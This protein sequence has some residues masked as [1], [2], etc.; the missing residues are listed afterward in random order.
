MAQDTTWAGAV[1]SEAD[2]NAFLMGEGGA[3]TTFT[4]TLV[5]SGAVTKT[6]TYASYA[7]FGRLIVGNMLLTCTGAGT[8]ANAVT[9]GLP[10]AASSGVTQAVGAGTLFDT[11]ATLNYVGTAQLTSTTTMAIIANAQA[12]YLGVSS[13]TAALASGDTI[14]VSF[15]YQA[16][17]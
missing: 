4:P 9:I 15:M 8:A 7:R 3:W 10:V 6:V 2:I 11:S 12:N 5:Q 17:T 1:L 14:G 13:F 16:A